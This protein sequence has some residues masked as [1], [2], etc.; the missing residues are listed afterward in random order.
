M[1]DTLLYPW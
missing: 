1:M